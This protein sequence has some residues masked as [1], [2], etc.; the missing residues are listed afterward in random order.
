[1][2]KPTVILIP[3]L[4]ERD[5]LWAHQLDHLRE[6]ADPSVLAMTQQP[7]RAAMA[8]S[9][10]KK[11]PARF[12]LAGHDL[13]GWVALEVA[14]RAPERIA[15]LILI[16]TWARPDPEACEQWRHRMRR[17]E[18]GEFAAVLE[19][20]LRTLF[21]PD[22]YRDEPFMAWFRRLQRDLSAD[23]YRR[24][25]EAL[26]RDYDTMALLPKIAG[27]TLVI[28]GRED[29]LVSRDDRNLLCRDIR[30]ATPALVEDCG[31]VAPMEQ[32]QAVTALMRLFLQE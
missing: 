30:K 29:R 16:N 26:V 10:L 2:Q 8:E 12:A 14:A 31:H 5:W 6:V 15:K 21:H 27:P 19:E 24:Q 17:I 1:V 18:S 25:V 28:H 22:C 4:G 3:G 32:P 11:A 7:T 9:V 23:T 13:G 20:R